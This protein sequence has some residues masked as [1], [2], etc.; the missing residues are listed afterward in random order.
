MHMAGESSGQE[1]SNFARRRA[2]HDLDL[3]YPIRRARKRWLRKRKVLIR[4]K[5]NSYGK[6]LERQ[7]DETSLYWVN[8]EPNRDFS[9]SSSD[10]FP[11]LRPPRRLELVHVRTIRT[12][13]SIRP[14]SI[15]TRRPEDLPQ[16]ENGVDRKKEKTLYVDNRIQQRHH[17]VVSECRLDMHVRADLGCVTTL[18]TRSEKKDR[19]AKKRKTEEES[20]REFFLHESWG[21]MEWEDEGESDNRGSKALL[22]L[23]ESLE[24]EREGDARVIRKES[25]PKHVN[26]VRS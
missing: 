6:T 14:C 16:E 11:S 26:S 10:Q 13:I 1:N 9:L 17:T 18:R 20:K 15:N 3:E 19:K 25:E 5:Q 8:A 24:G 2:E 23:R 12:P 22:W 7:L 21:L 4:R